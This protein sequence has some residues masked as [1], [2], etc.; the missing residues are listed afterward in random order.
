MQERK[1]EFEKFVECLGKQKDA[2]D[3]GSSGFL[4]N[5][6]ELIQDITMK[7]SNRVDRYSNTKKRG[8]IAF[9]V[10]RLILRINGESK[11]QAEKVT[12]SIYYPAESM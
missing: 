6:D 10:L 4:S 5:F 1:A 2:L 8:D 7:Q 3:S 9:R 12:S 11:I